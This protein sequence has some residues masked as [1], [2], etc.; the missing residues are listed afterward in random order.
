M[1]IDKYGNKHNLAKDIRADID[2]ALSDYQGDDEVAEIQD[3]IKSEYF[4]CLVENIVS[5]VEQHL[6]YQVKTLGEVVTEETIR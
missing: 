3:F 1:R 6:A 5:T 4:A 2:L